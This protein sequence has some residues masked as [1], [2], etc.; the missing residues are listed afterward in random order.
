[1][2]TYS[3]MPGLYPTVAMHLLEIEPERRPVKQ[4]LTLMNLDLAT[5]VEAEVDKLVKPNF[6]REV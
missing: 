1:M 2:W 5:K 3:E 4:A 6:I